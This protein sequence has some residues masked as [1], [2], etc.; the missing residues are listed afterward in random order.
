MKMKP[1][2]TQYETSR[3]TT[4]KTTRAPSER[5]VRRHAAKAKAKSVRSDFVAP[6]PKPV[7][8][9]VARRNK[10]DH[11]VAAVVV[12]VDHTEYLE[13]QEDSGLVLVIA[14]VTCRMADVLKLTFEAFPLE[15]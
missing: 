7:A 3:V 14:R 13:Y 10:P 2:V 4:V 12:P 11:Q 1:Q 6:A 15:G 9:P 8:K 5:T